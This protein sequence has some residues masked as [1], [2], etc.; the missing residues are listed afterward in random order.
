MKTMTELGKANIKK[1]Y[2]F[3]FLMNFRLSSGL[4]DIY[5]L[6]RN[7]LDAN[8]LSEGFPRDFTDYGS[9]YRFDSRSFGRKLSRTTGRCLVCKVFS[10]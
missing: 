2:L 9:S 1:T 8:R 4:D 10:Y 5:G 6:Q 7:E 3:S